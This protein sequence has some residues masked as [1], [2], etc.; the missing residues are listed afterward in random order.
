MERGENSLLF[1]SMKC[2]VQTVG[3]YFGWGQGQRREDI[4][5]FILV[6][7]AFI[8]N[9]HGVQ[10]THIFTVF[11]FSLSLREFF[12]TVLYFCLVLWKKY[13]LSADSHRVWLPLAVV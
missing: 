13:F 1:R 2:H 9:T 8:P 4:Y 10:R 11:F 7:G 6:G 5:R 12:G 3:K